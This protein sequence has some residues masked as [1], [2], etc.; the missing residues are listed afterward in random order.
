MAGQSD[1]E[2]D[3]P[4]AYLADLSDFKLDPENMN[5]HTQRGYEMVTKS[6]EK[7]GYGRPAFAA[8]D[9]TVLGGNLSTMEVAADLGIG[10]GKVFVVETAGDIPIIHKRRDIEA[11]STEAVLLAVEDNQ[12]AVVSVN[13]DPE[14]MQKQ[15][16]K[17][18]NFQ[19]IF[20]EKEEIDILSFYNESTKSDGSLLS[21][22]D[23]T[24]GEPRH[25]VLQ[26][27]V[28]RLERHILICCEVLTEWSLW[29]PYL[30]EDNMIFAPYPGVFI[31]LTLKADEHTLLMVQ[32]DPYIAGHIL[33]RFEEVNGEK[34][35]SRD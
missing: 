6:Q 26:G 19:G 34:N 32:P 29:K 5:Q 23:V 7:R 4:V 10:E 18:V 22:L 1:K 13:F 24:I 25:E 9:G 12:S 33:D 15:K 35:I 31:P 30:D 28:W 21:L 14:M 17:G 2:E 27:E 3:G 11:G 20:T 16:E 8:E